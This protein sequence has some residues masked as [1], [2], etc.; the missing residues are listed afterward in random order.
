M[1]DE[2]QPVMS[3][4]S[5][6]LP[7]HRN[8]RSHRGALLSTKSTRPLEFVPSAEYSRQPVAALDGAIPESAYTDRAPRVPKGS[9]RASHPKRKPIKEEYD[10]LTDDDSDTDLPKPFAGGEQPTKEDV[11]RFEHGDVNQV[12]AFKKKPRISQ[13]M[14]AIARRRRHLAAAQQ[15]TH[16]NHTEAGLPPGPAKMQRQCLAFAGS[17][18]MLGLKDLPL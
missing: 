11:E 4:D 6:S 18:K 9:L 15:H 14:R 2:A 5:S 12:G 17:L 1:G 8:R 3:S 10:V 13:R 16:T 7:S